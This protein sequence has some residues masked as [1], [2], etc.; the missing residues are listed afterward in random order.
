MAEAIKELSLETLYRYSNIVEQNF[1]LNKRVRAQFVSRATML[2]I[3]V[4][5]ICSIVFADSTFAQNGNDSFAGRLTIRDG[6][7]FSASVAGSTFEEFDPT[8][9]FV[10]HYPAGGS[11]WWSWTAA[12]TGFAVLT[13]QSHE[14]ADYPSPI[15]AVYAGN[16]LSTLNLLNWYEVSVYMRNQAF[17]G[18]NTT[19]GQPYSLGIV[20]DPSD[21]FLEPFLISAA[22][23]PLI[24]ESP[25]S[26]SLN[27]G[28]TALFLVSS[29][30]LPAGHAQWQF[31]SVDIPNATNSTLSLYNVT[32]AQSGIYTVTIDATNNTGAIKRTVSPPATLTVSGEIFPPGIS[33]R[34]TPA[35]TNQF[36]VKV[37]GQLRQW[38]LVESTQDFL[39][40]QVEPIDYILD[41]VDS[42]HEI[43]LPPSIPAQTKFL[44]AR[45]LGNTQQSCATNLKKIQFAKELAAMADHRAPGSACAVNDIKAYI[46]ELPRCPQGG[47][48][49]YNAY[50]TMPVCSLAAFGHTQ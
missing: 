19:A 9:L 5:T 16:N 2:K 33:I 32:Q 3:L 38:Y 1:C 12:N 30:S 24:I 43:P 13:K 14:P 37:M 18:F 41:A 22:D 39:T 42:D 26:Q 17:V 44:R 46:G 8:Q 28:D 48:Y 34:N 47:I 7:Q 6:Q 31:N 4:I 36:F 20:G 15:F 11:K 49:T 45:H 40:W 50:E 27:A 23:N 29:P 10:W 21:S 25:A 35:A